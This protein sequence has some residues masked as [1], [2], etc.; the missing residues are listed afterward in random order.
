MLLPVP[1]CLKI[2]GEL[3]LAL[4]VVVVDAGKS[5]VYS[6]PFEL[7]DTPFLYFFS[8]GDFLPDLESFDFNSGLFVEDA[9]APAFEE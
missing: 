6:T 7:P 4:V 9:D 1:S 2:A 3:A 5:G 8:L